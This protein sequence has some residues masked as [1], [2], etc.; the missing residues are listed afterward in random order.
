MKILN[1]EIDSSLQYIRW[2]SSLDENLLNNISVN[3]ISGHYYL[4]NSALELFTAHGLDEEYDNLLAKLKAL[5][6]V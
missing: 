6:L 5:N 1:D 4:L 3:D 2:Y